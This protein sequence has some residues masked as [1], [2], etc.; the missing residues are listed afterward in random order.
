MSA[1]EAAVEVADSIESLTKAVDGIAANQ[2]TVR[3][4]LAGQALCGLLANTEI[5][6]TPREF[7]VMAASHADA[8]IAELK[9]KGQSDGK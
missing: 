2:P 4:R 8:L 1:Y 5:Q 6:G 3:E 9:K 7:A